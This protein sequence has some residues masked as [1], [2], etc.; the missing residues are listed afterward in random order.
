MLLLLASHL[1]WDI[2][3]FS[4]ASAREPGRPQTE[5]SYTWPSLPPPERKMTCVFFFHDLFGSTTVMYRRGVRTR[6]CTINI[7][8]LY[9]EVVSATRLPDTRYCLCMIPGIC[10]IRILPDLSR[11]PFITDTY[12][13]WLLQLILLFK[14]C[15][16][17]CVE[18][19]LS[20]IIVILR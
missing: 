1:C 3:I 4:L 7:I 20:F 6:T 9:E 15:C 14:N 18:T 10:D 19:Y 11:V 2:S 5:I 12:C 17:Y 13:C 8:L 16:T